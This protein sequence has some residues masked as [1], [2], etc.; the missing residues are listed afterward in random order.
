MTMITI[1]DQRPEFRE[2]VAAALIEEGFSLQWPDDV[3]DWLAEPGRMV[4]ID[5]TDAHGVALLQRLPL[6]TSRFVAVSK[7]GGTGETLM[8]TI[9]ALDAVKAALALAASAHRCT[10][11]PSRWLM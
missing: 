1:V 11:R 7:S 2:I 4:I 10:I 5:L 8:Q 6:K 9:A 3:E